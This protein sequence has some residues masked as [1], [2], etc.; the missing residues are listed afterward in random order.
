MKKFLHMLLALALMAALLTGSVYAALDRN[1]FSESVRLSDATRLYSGTQLISTT[2]G[3]K[4]A[5]EHYVRYDGERDVRP[6]VAFGSEIYGASTINQIAKKLAGN[7]LSIVAGINASFFD[8]ETGIPYGLVVTDGVLRTAS[9]DM[10][11]VGFF[12][13]GS[14]I[15]G[16]PELELR[17][18]TPD[19]GETPIFYNKRLNTSNGIGLYSRDY[20]SMTKNKV[21]A[22]NLLLKPTGRAEWLTMNGTLELEIT[23][24]K[25]DTASCSIP[26]GHFVLSI[27]ENSIYASA[28]DNMK[29]LRQGDRVTI[30]TSCARDWENVMYACS[31]SEL[32]VENGVPCEE[33]TLDSEKKS[34][35]R[36]AI[37]IT[38]DNALILY[39]V[40]QVDSSSGGMNLAELADRMAEEGCVTALNLDGGGSTSL[41][42]VYPGYSAG[43]TVNSPEDGSLRA[44]ANFIFL[45]RDTTRARAAEQLFLYPYGM[46]AVL[47]GAQ[48]NMTVKA[49]DGSY[50][51]AELPGDV[52]YGAD[53]GSV[54]EKGVLTVDDDARGYVTVYAGSG[55]LETSVR[56]PVLD[57]ITELSIRRA[58]ANAGS[59]KL[60]VAG[61]SAV[62]L[63][64]TAG[65][66]GRSVAVKNGSFRWSVS[67]ELGK[68]DGN[69]VFTAVE[70]NQKRT[71]TVTVSFGDVKAELELTVVPGNPF[72]DMKTH[73][74]KDYVNELYLDGV[75]TGSTG[76]DGKLYYRPNDSMTRQEFVVA[77]MR[78]LGVDTS[79]YEKT[80]LPFED[81]ASIARWAQN[82]VKAAYKLGYMG[83][84][85]S[86]GKLYAKPTATISRQE[87][88]VILARSQK[89]KADTTTALDQFSDA[90]KVAKWA[91]PELAAMVQRGIISGSK[92]KLNPTGNVTRAEV[93]KML[94]AMRTSQG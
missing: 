29:S 16:S 42:A 87:A 81:A 4:A 45:V 86:G 22:Y 56:L 43:A 32:L 70:T 25:A 83:G 20:D 57:E 62:E 79:L 63:T 54:S 6:I 3:V 2:S 8:T 68:I 17:L 49:A 61:G 77:L 44:C 35:S 31:G 60:N 1:V 58:G 53:G 48:V 52:S 38:K 92:G 88:M 14:A 78:Y 40:D 10:P 94:Y 33:F 21:A 7:D 74:A 90:S 91:Q 76:S 82:A 34:A 67:E 18:C 64:A 65:Y 26:E 55:G 51:A 12:S 13:D 71:G 11:S 41:G 69:G 39:T 72:A 85:S 47:P 24:I 30:R 9:T 66:Y 27:A 19:G 89:L 80:E 84:S 46:Q 37:G 15:I 75:L 36:T 23:G 50:M 5:Q 93:A 59:K 73:W 28:L